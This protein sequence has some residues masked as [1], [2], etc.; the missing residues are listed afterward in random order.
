MFFFS[1]SS[2]E[3]DQLA[4]ASKS[5]ETILLALPNEK[6]LSAPAIL[7]PIVMLC[8]APLAPS[9]ALPIIILLEPVVTPEPAP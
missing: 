8:D 2:E 9:A 4:S 3:R 7:S 6:S 1:R 5:F